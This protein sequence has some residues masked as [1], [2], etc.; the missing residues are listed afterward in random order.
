MKP[1]PSSQNDEQDQEIIKLL[2]AL[3]SFPSPYPPE[4]LTTRRAAFLAQI[5]RLARAEAEEGLNAGDEEMIRLLGNLNSVT[6]EY[7]ADWQAARRSAFLQQIEGAQTVTGFDK[8]RASIRHIFQY[9]IRIPTVPL[10]DMRRTSLIVAGLIAAALIGSL[11]FR[12]TEQVFKPLPL[13]GIVEPTRTSTHSAATVICRPE[14]QMPPCPPRELAASQ[15]LADQANGVAR[16]AISSD[17]GFHK[18][19][20]VNDGRG[21]ASWVSN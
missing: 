10:A 1:H 17:E 18:A 14:D 13:Q 8:L 19:A 9:K 21:G 2:Q 6:P 16:P 3:G 20:Y 11:L 5:E 4:L 15:D 12:N 7:P